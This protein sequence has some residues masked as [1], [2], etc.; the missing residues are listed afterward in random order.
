MLKLPRHS[1]RPLCHHTPPL[2]FCPAGVRCPALVQTYPVTN[3]L[4]PDLLKPVASLQAGASARPVCCCCLCRP[5]HGLLLMPC[6]GPDLFNPDLQ[7]PVAAL[8][9]GA[10]TTPV[11]CCCVCKAL[12]REG[13]LAAHALPW[14]RPIQSRLL[15]PDLR[16]PLAALDDGASQLGAACCCWL[17]RPC[18]ELLLIWLALSRPIES[19]PT[20]SRP[21]KPCVL[22]PAS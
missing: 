1:A 6:L 8:H 22:L 7:K 17:C 2:P 11:C 3:L 5:C 16:K 9:A 14:S 18:R 13:L 12:P 10:S 21:A 15:S 4:S 19:R 20:Q